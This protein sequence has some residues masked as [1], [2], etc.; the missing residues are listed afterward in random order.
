MAIDCGMENNVVASTPSRPQKQSSSKVVPDS[1]RL[2]TAEQFSLPNWHNQINMVDSDGPKFTDTTS[3][4]TMS[5][6][7]IV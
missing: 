1:S 6:H 7:E 5:D 4:N 2:R 3:T